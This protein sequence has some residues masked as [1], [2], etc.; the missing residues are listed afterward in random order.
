MKT[1]ED[2]ITILLDRYDMQFAADILYTID[3][4]VPKGTD[5]NYD[6]LYEIVKSVR[7]SSE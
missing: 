6:K 5:V 1:R 3:T 7:D 2:L 4:K